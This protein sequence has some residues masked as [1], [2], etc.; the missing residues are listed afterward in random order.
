MYEQIVNFLSENYL[1]SG[2]IVVA[3]FSSLLYLLKSIPGRIWELIKKYGMSKLEVHSD[4]ATYFMVDKWLANQ[5]WLK[6]SNRFIL[7][8]NGLLL[9]ALDSYTIFRKGHIVRVEKR[10]DPGA[11]SGTLKLRHFVISIDIFPR[12]KKLISKI[13]D[14]IKEFEIKDSLNLNTGKWGHWY[15]NKNL[16]MRQLGS[17]ILPEKIKTSLITSAKKFINSEDWYKLKGIPYHKGYLFYGPPGNGKTSIVHAL[18]S[19]IKRSIYFISLGNKDLNDEDFTNLISGVSK[20]SIVVIEDIDC[21]KVSHDRD[22]E[23]K[24]SNKTEG[25]NLST[26]LNV[27]DGF[28]SP[29]GT[30]FVATTNHIDKLDPA[31]IRAGRFDEHYFINKPSKK[32]IAAYL[33]HMYEEDFSEEFAEKLEG[34]NMADLQAKILEFNKPG[35]FKVAVNNNCIRF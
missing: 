3:T 33:T 20:S 29:E 31:L 24:E 11:A 14:E 28:L 27:L 17:V 18:A 6:R 1:A 19:E 13:I 12:S 22:E 7:G 25:L 21:F 5:P 34:I 16:P 35:E 23:N 30:I 32:E 26:L 4:T 9:P 2:G 8:E 10:M 15:S